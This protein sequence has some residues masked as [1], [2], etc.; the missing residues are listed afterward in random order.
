M[1]AKDTRTETF[2]T[3]M[4]VDFQYTNKVTIDDLVENWREINLSRPVPMREEAVIEYSALME[5]G[6]PAPAPILY[7]TDDGYA[8]LD[9]V[10]RIAAAEL[11][12]ISRLAAYA[13]TCDSE[14]LRAAIN[15]LANARLQGRAEA[16]EWTR[17]RAVEVL[18]I[19]RRMSVD[20]VAR[21]GG[22]PKAAIRALEVTLGW[23][24]TIKDIGGPALPDTLVEVVSRYVTKSA[25]RSAAVPSAEFLKTIKAAKFS[26]T[27]AEP[28][29]EDFFRASAKNRKHFKVLTDRLELFKAEPE[30]QTRILGRQSS[31]LSHDVHLRRALKTVI[32]VLDDIKKSGDKL[33]YMA[34]YY[35]LS[36]L[37]DRKLHKLPVTKPTKSEDT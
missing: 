20:E 11:A 19:K 5:G 1:F 29:I 6:S 37:I 34:E 15:V 30:V 24:K 12:G 36:E 8:I 23:G 33:L 32:T 17:R 9:G 22:W 13:V 16:P 7:Q 28:Y 26:A 14:D 35:K 21:M 31:A 27:D 4:G 3:Q 18:V 10:Q 2:L 25:L